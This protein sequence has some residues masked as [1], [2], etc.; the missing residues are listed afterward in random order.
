MVWA[1]HAAGSGLTLEQ[2]KEELLNAVIS[3]RT[4]GT[5]HQMTTTNALSGCAGLTAK[6]R[7]KS[8]MKCC[9]R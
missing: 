8:A 5:P 9:S 7:L 1:K 6:R 4:E 2:I 3:A